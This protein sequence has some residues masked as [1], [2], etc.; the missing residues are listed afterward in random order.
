MLAII[1]SR[2]EVPP[3]RQAV[4]QGTAQLLHRRLRPARG[5]LRLRRHPRGAQPRQDR[6][7]AAQ[8]V[9]L[10]R[11]A[12]AST[13]SRPSARRSAARRWSGPTAWPRRSASR[14]SGSRTTPSTSR[15]C[16]SRTASSPWRCRKAREFGFKT[17]GCASTGNLANS[18]AANAAAAGLEA[19]IFVPADLEQAKILGTSVYGAKVIARRRHLRRGQSPLHAGRLQVRL[20]LRQHQ[21]AAVLRRGLEDDRLRDRRAA[22]LADARSTSSARWPAAA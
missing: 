13:A 21:P 14:S 2:L 3:V 4:S 6:A 9:A 8:H 16:R 22:R 20:G 15:R 12:A 11:A 5:R 1:R 10:P 7:A 19:Y 17:V 18:V